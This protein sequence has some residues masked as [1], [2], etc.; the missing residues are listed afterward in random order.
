MAATALMAVATVT[1]LAT[2]GSRRYLS[3][4]RSNS[5]GM[6]IVARFVYEFHTKY[7]HVIFAGSE[8]MMERSLHGHRL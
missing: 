3:M 6:A 7:I 4:A 1:M 2:A 8:P 5:S